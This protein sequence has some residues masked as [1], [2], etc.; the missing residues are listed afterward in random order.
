MKFTDL[1]QVIEQD[2]LAFLQSDEIIGQRPG[3]LIEPGAV[4]SI[5]DEDVTKVLAAGMDGKVGL[6]FMV[7]PIEDLIDETPE[8]IFGALKLPIKIQWVENVVLNQGPRGA[9]IPIRSMASYCQKVLKSY[10]AQNL[11]T[12]FIPEENAISLFTP[13]RDENLRVC[14]INLFTYESDPVNFRQCAS[15]FLTSSAPV[16]L[17]AGENV[18]PF[19]VTIGA[20]S[21]S[22]VFW[23]LDGSHP[24]KANA[25]ATEWDGQPVI[26]DAPCFF[27]AR[28]FKAGALGSAT[29]SIYFA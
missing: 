19:T 27:R 13:S 20:E 28:A 6:G 24:H 10:S 9:K 12:D 21:G 17:T 23:T 25:A 29:S 26:I 4:E 18:Y 14:Q 1:Y 5:L 15:P 22:A 7:L 3:A 2:I 8:V 11:T 16:S